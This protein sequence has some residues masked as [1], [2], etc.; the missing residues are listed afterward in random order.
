MQIKIVN[1]ADRSNPTER[2]CQIPLKQKFNIT[3]FLNKTS[4]IRKF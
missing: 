3:Y 2:E 4:F 1:K